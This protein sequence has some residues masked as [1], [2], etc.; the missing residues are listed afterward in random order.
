MY[1]DVQGPLTFEGISVGNFTAIAATHEVV[2]T[3]NNYMETHD[4]V[5]GTLTLQTEFDKQVIVGSSEQTVVFPFNGGDCNVTLFFKPAIYIAIPVHF[6][7]KASQ[8]S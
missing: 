4:P 1:N 8:V 6:S 5:H 2:M 7:N 3:F